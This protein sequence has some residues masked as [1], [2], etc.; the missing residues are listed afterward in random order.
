MAA[1]DTGEMTTASDPYS[2]NLERSHDK[3]SSTDVEIEARLE[4]A[5]ETVER[6]LEAARSLLDEAWTTA[7]HVLG[8]ERGA[9]R[10]PVHAFDR[11]EHDREAL[12]VAA[13]HIREREKALVAAWEELDEANRA[14]E[15]TRA[16]L[17]KQARDNGYSL[18]LAESTSAAGVGYRPDRDA[19][20]NGIPRGAL[21]VVDELV[22]IEIVDESED[23]ARVQETK[24]ERGDPAPSSDGERSDQIDDASSPD[25][26]VGLRVVAMETIDPKDVSTAMARLRGSWTWSQSSKRK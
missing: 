26:V 15:L 11:I 20:P 22:H 12:R 6:A 2:G 17:I 3:S 7:E 19:T 16:E 10:S 9:G 1:T 21:A 8:E 5:R 4:T 18:G 14:F 23:E 13:R 24:A 25:R